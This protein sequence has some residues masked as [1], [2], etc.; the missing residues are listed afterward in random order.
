MAWLKCTMLETRFD[1]CISVYT[2]NKKIYSCPLWLIIGVVRKGGCP[3]RKKKKNASLWR[4]QYE[5]KSALATKNFITRPRQ[6]SCPMETNINTLF[7]QND[8]T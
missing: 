5:G 6:P 4:S 1:W 2:L 3:Q 8:M 7:N